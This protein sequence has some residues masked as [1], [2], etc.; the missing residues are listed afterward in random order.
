V[1]NDKAGYSCQGLLFFT[2]V[3]KSAFWA[4][5]WPVQ[6]AADKWMFKALKRGLGQVIYCSCFCY[7]IGIDF[8][9]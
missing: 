7:I 8:E 3:V 2:E 5:I 9:S 1:G 6:R 4:E